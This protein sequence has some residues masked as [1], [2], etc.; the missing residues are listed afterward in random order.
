ME[1]MPDYDQSRRVFL[2]EQLPQGRGRKGGGHHLGLL[3]RLADKYQ[4]LSVVSPSQVILRVA[5]DDLRDLRLSSAGQVEQVVA[6]VGGGRLVDRAP[7]QAARLGRLRGVRERE[8]VRSHSQHLPAARTASGSSEY[9][10]SSSH[11]DF[12]LGLFFS[13]SETE[14]LSENRTRFFLKPKQSF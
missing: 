11:S 7:H 5:G 9:F 14:S 10:F 13:S 4:M 2:T 1:G 6:P 12:S 3:I 8:G